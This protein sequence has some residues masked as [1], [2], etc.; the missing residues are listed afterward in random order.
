MPYIMVDIEAD[1]PVP[2]L[3]SMVSLGA[4]VVEPKLT[5]TFFAN[6]KPISD[7]WNNDALQFIGLTRAQTL[8][9]PNPETSLLSFYNWLNEVSGDRQPIFVADNNGFDWSFINYYFHRF[10]KRNP[11][12]HQS[13]HVP[14]IFF[15]AMRKLDDSYRKYR[16]TP[17]THDPV[18]DA[19]G[20]AEALI[21][22]ASE[23]NIELGFE[24]GVG[25]D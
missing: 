4:I 18:D 19:R 17:H 2:G 23:Y 12:G 6:F 1:G 24:N 21:A 11:F 9:Y 20:N 15:G 16:V 10:Q 22:L 14:S 7:S 13:L 8:T 3:Y 25:R 5:R